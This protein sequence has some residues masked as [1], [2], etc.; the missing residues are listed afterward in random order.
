M[1]GIEPRL[2]GARFPHPSISALLYNEY[3]VVPDA[4]AT[5]AWR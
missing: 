2:W 4:T 3:R 5:E 1:M